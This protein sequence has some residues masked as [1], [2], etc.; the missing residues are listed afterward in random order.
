MQTI[1]VGGVFSGVGGM[2]L[3]VS[4]ACVRYNMDVS[5]TFRLSLPYMIEWE[6]ACQN[7][8]RHNWNALRPVIHGDVRAVN[9]AELPDTD[10]IVGGF[11]CTS[12]SVAG[13]RKGFDGESG[14]FYELADILGAKRP[15]WFI[16]ENVPGLLYSHNGFEFGVVLQTLAKFGYSIGWRMLNSAAFSTPQRRERV[17]IVGHLG[18]RACVER[19][20]FNTGDVGNSEKN[21]RAK[22]FL[23]L[24]SSTSTTDSGKGRYA[25]G[26]EEKSI[27]I[28][29]DHTKGNGWG[30]L[31]DG[32][33]HTAGATRDAVVVN[34]DG[35][36]VLRF[37]TPREYE[38]MQG[39]PIDWTRDC[40]LP[41]GTKSLTPTNKRVK[42]MTNAVHVGTVSEIAYR[43][44]TEFAKG[45]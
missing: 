38:R 42:M 24:S 11:P 8:L 9:K 4:N 19:V 37:F 31:L 40:L 26:V 20:L 44:L 32:T 5:P 12:V 2:E 28:K 23:S 17:Y 34:K 15:S 35:E 45:E 21:L 43:I 10:I 6:A 13:T 27:V 14:L 36:D 41:D 39:F 25:T 3:A 30:V 18:E 1:S 29:T 22:R 33:C 16:I 7:V